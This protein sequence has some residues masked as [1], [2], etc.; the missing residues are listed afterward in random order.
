M[1]YSVTLGNQQ[2]GF[3][4]NYGQAGYWDKLFGKHLNNV[5][6]G[7]TAKKSIPLLVLSVKFDDFVP[8][9]SK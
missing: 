7:M 3:T 1:G 2:T 9:T 6:F 4:Y 8:P 5:F